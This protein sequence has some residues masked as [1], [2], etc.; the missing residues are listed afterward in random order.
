M[1]VLST[2]GRF[3]GDVFLGALNA[4]LS[5][6]TS[7]CRDEFASSLGCRKLRLLAF[8]LR[9]VGEV[10]TCLKTL[11]NTHAADCRHLS[12]S[13]LET[14]ARMNNA[15][16]GPREFFFFFFHIMRQNLFKTR[17]IIGT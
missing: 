6:A 2:Q 9:T 14:P 11:L 4:A 5:N 10:G 13:L 8:F 1:A 12:I 7:V 16:P 15:K 17:T 3:Q